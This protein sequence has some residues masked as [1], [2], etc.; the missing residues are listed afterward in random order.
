MTSRGVASKTTFLANGSG[1]V[2]DGAFIDTELND[3]CLYV[4]RGGVASATTLGDHGVL[5]VS[6]SAT[7]QDTTIQYGGELAISNG[8]MASDT[9]VNS[10][11]S[12]IVS[13]GATARHTTVHSGG[14]MTIDYRAEIGGRMVFESGA[15]ISA[16]KG[17]VIDF[18][19][20]E[21]TAGDAA[22]LNNWEM[23]NGR[24]IANYTITVKADQAFGTYALAGGAAIFNMTITVKTA[25]AELGTIT[26]G[27]PLIVGD[28]AYTLNRVDDLL[29]LTIANVTP[30]P[31]VE[32]ATPAEIILTISDTTHAYFGATGG[33]KVQTDQ[34]IVWQDLSPLSGDYQVLGQGYTVA[35]KKATDIYI[36]SP[37]AKY[38]GVYTT[39]DT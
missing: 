31:V 32:N 34:T 25:D 3:A 21:Q 11:G 14:S 24:T 9:E 20:A 4:N 2:Y 18:T 29:S 22:L 15:V 6:S 27:L 16:S 38:I 1:G 5:V 23:I 19:V 30:P 39:D 28:I 26:G 17:A 12:I 36:Y 13:S 10:S 37:S 7:V 33:W 35:G 8:G